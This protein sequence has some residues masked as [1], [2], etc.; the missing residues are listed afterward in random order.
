M[1]EKKE[2]LKSL[3]PLKS[4]IELKDIEIQ[5]FERDTSDLDPE[6]SDIFDSGEKKQKSDRLLEIIKKDKVT[7]SE[8]Y[9]A[10][11]DAIK[12]LP[13]KH[14]IV[15]ERHYVL[16]Q[17]FAEIACAIGRSE[18]YV[19]NYEREGIELIDFQKLDQDSNR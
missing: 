3:I 18:R 19:F 8:R 9:E 16:G 4:L 5:D 14:Q 2:I 1:N 12:S 10:I 7:L 17:T 11:Y 13:E 15:L 6:L